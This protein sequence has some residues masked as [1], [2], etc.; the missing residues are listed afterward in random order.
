VLLFAC[1]LGA[2]SL[3]ADALWYDEFL[4]IYNAGGTHHGPLP[5]AEIL[6]RLTEYNPWQG[7]GYPLVLAGWG[8]LAGWTGFAGRAFSLLTGLLAIAWTYRAGRD[9]ASPRVGLSAAIALGAS[10]FFIDYLH[11][12]RAYT[13]YALFTAMTMATYWRLITRPAGW[14]TRALFLVGMIGLFYTHYFAALAVVGIALY[15]LFFVSKMR[16]W[17][18]VV[19]IMGIAGLIFLPWFSV[20]LSAVGLAGEDAARQTRALTD[21]EILQSLLYA[22]SNG[23]VIL[24]VVVAGAAAFARSRAV[25][26]VAFLALCILI[27]AL[28][29][30]TAIPVI[31]H[32]RYLMALWPVLALLVGLGVDQLARYRVPTILVLVIWVAAGLWNTFNPAFIDGLFRDVHIQLFHTH[33]PVHTMTRV[34]AA[35]VQTDDG[36]AF[37]V[38]VNGWAWEGAF[39]YYMH[40]L[41]VS[42]TTF[43]GLSTSSREGVFYGSARDYLAD[44]AR[45]WLGV[46]Q[47]VP[48]DERLAEFERAL[49]DD[50]FS[51]CGNY[52]DMPDLRLDLYSRGETC[53]LP[54]NAAPL[55]NY[56]DG[57][58]L[59]SVEL[60]PLDDSL[61]VL[62]AWSLAPE[63]PR[64]TYSVALHVVDST[65][66][67]VAQ[68]DYGLPPDAFACRVSNIALTD[69]PPGDYTLMGIVYN[70]SSGERLPA[71]SVET[72][73]QGERLALGEF[74]RP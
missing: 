65:D 9:M 55:I 44:K 56:G 20:M 38:P 6:R 4:A 17:W 39:D 8:A 43:D 51:A 53:C 60:E 67:L 48:P 15:H 73:A 66:T 64:G 47:D 3:D 11:E 49:S 34:I 32:V 30:N 18:Q 61:R 45:V 57:I 54:S 63:V 33:L 1:W 35:N 25:G 24:L 21:V 72:G 62:A 23:I 41:P 69:L 2:R 42:D 29:L 31:T 71:T 5:P 13:L 12:L 28:I 40:P 36:V 52:L 59:I 70:W 58:Y 26:L 7:A 22:F 19:L 16:Q 50:G 68:A 74:T 14:G 46:E 27:F 37:D 10:A